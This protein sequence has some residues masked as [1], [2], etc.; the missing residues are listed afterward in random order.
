MQI[1]LFVRKKYTPSTLHM[2]LYENMENKKE[3]RIKHLV[4]EKWRVFR[5][6][7]GHFSPECTTLEL[8]SVSLENISKHL[9]FFQAIFFITLLMCW[10]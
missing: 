6:T 3:K 4:K 2:V 8:V 5:V 7:L 1:K 10:G 9:T